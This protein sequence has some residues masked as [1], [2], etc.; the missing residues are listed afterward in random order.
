MKILFLDDNDNRVLHA[1]EYFADDDLTIVRT[2][3]EAIGVLEEDK[4]WDVVML[5]HDLTPGK[6]FSPSD[7]ISGM[8][9]V[10]HIEVHPITTS[11][12]VVHSWNGG[13][14]MR[15]RDRLREAGYDTEYAP[16]AIV[17]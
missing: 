5:D 15:M 7:E 4:E 9:V 1:I 17:N 14:G 6:A 11:R 13:A 2:A 8:E 16:F 12:I 3:A 10:R